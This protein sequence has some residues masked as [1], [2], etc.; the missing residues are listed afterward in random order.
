MICRSAF[1]KTPS[2]ASITSQLFAPRELSP[3]PPTE[4]RPRR[5]LPPLPRTNLAFP[6][7]ALSGRTFILFMFAAKR[8]LLL[9]R[10]LRPQP[11]FGKSWIGRASSLTSPSPP[12]PFLD[13]PAPMPSQVTHP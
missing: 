2:S 8:F 3:S 11:S 12:S 5:P 13:S 6:A 10:E 9:G 4:Q 1:P 7:A